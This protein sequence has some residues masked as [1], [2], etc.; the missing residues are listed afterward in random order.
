MKLIRSIALNVVA[1]AAV[2]SVLFQLVMKR[3][4][5]ALLTMAIVWLAVKL[6]ED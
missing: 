2:W 5:S 1:G 4:V 6:D 3:P